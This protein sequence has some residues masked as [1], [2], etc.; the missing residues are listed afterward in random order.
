MPIQNCKTIE[1][2]LSGIEMEEVR[3]FSQEGTRGGPEMT[4]SCQVAPF[5]CFSCGGCCCSGPSS[6]EEEVFANV[7]TDL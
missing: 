3:I 6:P 1:L 5:P 2:D 4:A 7:H